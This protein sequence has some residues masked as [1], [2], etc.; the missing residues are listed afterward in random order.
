MDL[1]LNLRGIVAQQLIKRSDGKGRYP[2]IE[3]LVNTPLAKDYIRKGEIDKLK[4]LMKSSREQGM[5]TFDQALYDLYAANKISYEDALNAA[6]SKNEVRLKIKLADENRNSFV[7]D[8]M[9]LTD[10]DSQ[11]GSLY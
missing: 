1:S 8:N 10:T 6:D 3:I 4:E 5:Q 7:S 2:A 9:I 11:N